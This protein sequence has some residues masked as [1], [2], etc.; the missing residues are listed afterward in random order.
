MRMS[1]EIVAGIA[2]VA[3]YVSGIAIEQHA[4]RQ[5]AKNQANLTGATGLALDLDSS[6][7][8]VSL[9]Q[10]TVRTLLAPLILTAGM[11]S[12]TEAYANAPGD[13]IQQTP[14]VLE[15]I[16]DHSGATGLNLDGKPTVTTIN[17]LATQLTTNKINGEA[18]VAGSGQVTIVKSEKISGD[19]P[20]GAAPLDQALT[21]ALG[22]A[23]LAAK[24]ATGTESKRTSG[25]VLITNGNSVVG[26]PGLTAKT[27]QQTAPTYEQQTPVYVVNVERSSLANQATNQALKQIADKTHGKY[28]N[29]NETNAST[30]T[31]NV[32][33]SLRPEESRRAPIP[34]RNLFRILGA[35]GLAAVAGQYVGRK[36]KTIGRGAKGE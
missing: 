2:G 9:R 24:P 14:A 16:V 23:Q 1:P 3:G 8:P 25:V 5:V 11:A 10:K 26:T 32:M 22:K 35:I 15:V 20:F 12:A 31:D 30:I 13:L 33:A 21:I 18:L 19:R 6:M 27:N 29:A 4:I 34:N 36:N 7:H 17:T 28:W